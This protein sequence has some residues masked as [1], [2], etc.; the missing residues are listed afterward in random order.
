LAQEF[1]DW[2]RK[3]LGESQHPVFGKVVSGMAVVKAIEK[4]RTSDDNP[5][6]PVKMISMKVL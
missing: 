5:I 6:T 1:L 2:W 3:D 4:T